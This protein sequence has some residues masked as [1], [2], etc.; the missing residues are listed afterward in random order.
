[1]LHRSRGFEKVGTFRHLAKMTYGELAGQW[2]DTD[3]YEKLL[4]KPGE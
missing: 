3:V 1:G 4:P 2:R